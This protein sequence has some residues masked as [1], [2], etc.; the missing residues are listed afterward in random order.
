[1]VNRRNVSVRKRRARRSFARQFFVGFL[2]ALVFLLVG[3]AVWYGSRLESLTIT[4]V[5]VEGGE[6]IG[7]AAIQSVVEAELF[8]E[9]YRVVPKR[10]S[11]TYPE[12][13]IESKVLQM[14]RVSDVVLERPNNR[15]LIVRVSEYT[16]AALWCAGAD[17]SACVFL[18]NSG[19]AFAKAPPLSGAA[20]LRYVNSTIP[21]VD[22]QPFF[23]EF[24]RDTMSFATAARREL[25]LPIG[26]VEKIGEAEA[27][28]TVVGGGLLKVTLEEDV[29]HTL[30]NLR[31]LLASEEF[32]HL[33]PGNFQYID[34]RFGDKMFINEEF[35][36]ADKELSASST[37]E[38]AP[39]VDESSI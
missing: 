25:G 8:G 29:T 36:L 7:R 26:Q 18:D 37:S 4:D 15:S 27:T 14:E 5:S 24:M 17:S 13:K 12:A 30:D 11:W 23:Y 9:Y 28:F 22:Q 32:Q 39:E 10:F 1:M 21:E 2:L 34:L 31:V 35:G 20:M 6:T 16:P 38:M 3:G 33:R 19:Y